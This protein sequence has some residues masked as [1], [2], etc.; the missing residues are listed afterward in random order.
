MAKKEKWPKEYHGPQNTTQETKDW[1]NMNTSKT[2]NEVRSSWRVSSSCLTSSDK[3]YK[4]ERG[5][6][7]GYVKRNIFVVFLQLPIS[8]KELKLWNTK[9]NVLLKFCDWKYRKYSC[10]YHN[11]III[12][13]L[14]YYPDISWL[15]GQRSHFVGHF[16]GQSLA[17]EVDPTSCSS[18]Y[19]HAQQLA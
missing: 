17:D 6:D 2:E 11:Y 19:R 12:L 18:C 7:Y 10:A 8:W 1:F 5:R 9:S 15:L 16:F 4:R 13:P 14:W 3:S